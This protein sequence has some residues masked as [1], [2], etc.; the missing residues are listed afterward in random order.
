MKKSLLTILT[1][2][3]INSKIKKLKQSVKTAC[4]YIVDEL[5]LT[6]TITGAEDFKVVNLVHKTGGNLYYYKLYYNYKIKGVQYSSHKVIKIVDAEMLY[7]WHKE[8][9]KLMLQKWLHKIELEICR[10][11][12]VKYSK[13]TKLKVVKVKDVPYR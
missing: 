3:S 10:L 11:D 9:K 6:S 12:Q 7:K 2:K 13:F 1:L 5:V 8:L 4:M